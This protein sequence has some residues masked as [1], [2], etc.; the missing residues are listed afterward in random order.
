MS[1]F[2]LPI[3]GGLAIDRLSS[4]ERHELFI[5]SVVE[6]QFWK[7]KEVRPYETTVA[8]TS[9]IDC[10]PCLALRVITAN[11]CRAHKWIE[12]SLHGV[13]SR[14]YLFELSGFAFFVYSN[15]SLFTARPHPYQHHI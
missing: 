13:W 5:R 2:E 4:S 1:T 8:A 6:R 3:P 11:V 14:R 12:N 9:D 15:M 7:E 10:V